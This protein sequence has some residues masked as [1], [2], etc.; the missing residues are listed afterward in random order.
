[1]KVNEEIAN[2]PMMAISIKT[3]LTTDEA[4]IFLGYQPQ[5]LR[6]LCMRKKVPYYKKGHRLY[7]KKSELEDWMTSDRRPSHDEVW[8]EYEANR[9][10]KANRNN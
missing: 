6:A 4:A 1:M 9:I 5:T 3:V 2:N 10:K 8:K 7:F